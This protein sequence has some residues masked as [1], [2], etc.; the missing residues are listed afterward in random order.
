M[1]NKKGLAPLEI[2]PRG[3]AVN[4]LRAKTIK[5]KSNTSL[6]FLTGFTLIE[7]MI[8]VAIIGILTVVA[9]VLWGI[10]A[11]NKAA[12]NGYKTSMNSV[13]TFTEMCTGSGGTLQNGA[14]GT[15]IICIG[16]TEKYPAL[17]SKCSNITQFL[18][19]GSGS[20]WWV[21]TD[22]PCRSC[23]LHCTI[24]GCTSVAPNDQ[25]Y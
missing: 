4:G 12:V 17:S 6:K 22:Q 21:E 7:L 1:K 5:T 2:M 9:L 16:G 25:C 20:N 8:I 24:Y 3:S 10:S 23:K 18:V 15:G 19:G 13:R 11:Q 14:P